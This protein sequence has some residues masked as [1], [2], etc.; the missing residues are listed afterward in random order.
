MK[1][2]LSLATALLIAVSAIAQTQTWTLDKDHAKLGF[3]ATHMMISDVEGFFKTFDI[4]LAASDESFTN[5]KIE[6]TAQT[7]SIDTDNKKRDDHLRSADFFDVE[8]YPELTFKSTS[9]KKT[10]DKKYTLTG[11]LTMHG[12]TKPVKLDVIFN[13]TMV[14]PYTKKT[15]AGFKVTGIVK[16]SDYNLGNTFAD[17]MISDE[18]TVN[19][20]AEF[21]KD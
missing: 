20:N 4:K 19:A 3:T 13:G 18:I 17:A 2:I 16:R 21:I 6:L 1:K 9:F 11:D 8:K 5:T 7:N 12:V 15:V 10:G 14:H